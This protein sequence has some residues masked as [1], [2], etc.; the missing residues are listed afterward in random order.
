MEKIRLYVQTIKRLEACVNDEKQR[1]SIL[2]E[3]NCKMFSSVSNAKRIRKLG[4]KERMI[5][6][7]V[8][9]FLSPYACLIESPAYSRK[10]SVSSTLKYCG[11][12]T[13]LRRLLHVSKHF[14]DILRNTVSH[15]DV[16]PFLGL[17][18]SFLGYRYSGKSFKRMDYVVLQRA[19]QTICCL[20]H[21]SV[22][23]TSSFRSLAFDVPKKR[24]HSK[25]GVAAIR[26]E[27]FK[28][29]LEDCKYITSTALG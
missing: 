13:A 28:K 16:S 12:T 18:L 17:L 7:V 8:F 10:E 23:E 21:E 25:G 15:L 19:M 29:L 11:R 6:R 14:A 27:E 22:D 26:K 20:H 9:R 1:T 3:H 5:E 24:C 4:M 2:I